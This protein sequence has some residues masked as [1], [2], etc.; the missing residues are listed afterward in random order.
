MFSLD[1]RH[2]QYFGTITCNGLHGIMYRTLALFTKQDIGP[3]YDGAGDLITDKSEISQLLLEQF[4][5]VFPHHPPIKRSLTLI[6]F[7]LI[8]LTASPC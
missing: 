7:L 4:S 6:L 3:F 8:T 1:W 5:S 2:W